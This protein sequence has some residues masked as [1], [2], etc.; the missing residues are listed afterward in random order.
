[1]WIESGNECPPS[2][3]VQC[4]RAAR[5]DVYV[6]VCDDKI[7]VTNGA[8]FHNPLHWFHLK[9]KCRNSKVTH[10]L[11]F[12]FVIF[13]PLQF[14]LIAELNK[15]VCTEAT[16]WWAINNGKDK[17]FQNECKNSE[18]NQLLVCLGWFLVWNGQPIDRP[19][20]VELVELDC[21]A[22]K[23][24][25]STNFIW[26]LTEHKVNSNMETI[27]LIELSWPRV[28]NSHH[29]DDEYQ[30]AKMVRARV[31]CCFCEFFSFRFAI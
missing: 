2:N 29:F 26:N 8:P 14:D 7:C 18:S 9:C 27:R 10:I 6:C 23:P 3:F 21:I 24:F 1:M 15:C 4:T 31:D 25:N 13:F 11:H 17:H 28:N 5:T 22:M 16:M 20:I 19:S 30:C 12:L